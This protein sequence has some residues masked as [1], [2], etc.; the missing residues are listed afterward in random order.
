VIIL[1]L[2]LPGRPGLEVLKALRGSGIH[3]PVIAVTALGSV[4]ERVSGL[5]AGADDYVVKPFALV[6]LMARVEAVCRRAASRPP[7]VMQAGQLTLDLATRRITRES[8]EIELT[9]TEFSLLELLMR[10]A[11][12]VVTRKMLCEHLWESDW[13]GATNVI[14]VHINRLRGKLDKGFDES[15]IQTVRGRGY[16][17]RAS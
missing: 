13:E 2:M 3:T 9:P 8:R 16:A 1:D 12:Q 5:N 11:G 10:Y 17:L 6:E 4:E 7:A 15:V 14:E